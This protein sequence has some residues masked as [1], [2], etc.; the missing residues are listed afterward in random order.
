ME[1]GH[2]FSR[3]TPTQ[4]AGDFRVVPEPE[5]ADG[6]AAAID[7]VSPSAETIADGTYPLARSMYIYV[8]IPAPA[9]RPV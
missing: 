7:G 2:P 4:A 8:K 1:S 3:L 9:S 6:E 5:A